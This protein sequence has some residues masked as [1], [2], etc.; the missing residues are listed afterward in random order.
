L[1][2]KYKTLTVPLIVDT[3]VSTI[4][5]KGLAIEK[6]RSIYKLGSK[7]RHLLKFF[8]LIEYYVSKK[9]DKSKI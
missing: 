6:K 7:N 2:D 8:F 3:I 1:K 4:Y 5:D 9:K